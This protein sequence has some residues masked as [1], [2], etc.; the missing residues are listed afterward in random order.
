MSIFS[1]PVADALIH[2]IISSAHLWG[3]YSCLNFTVLRDV[4]QPCPRAHSECLRSQAHVSAQ[5]KLPR[6]GKPFLWGKGDRG[7]QVEGS[8]ED[9][10]RERR[11]RSRTAEGLLFPWSRLARKS[12]RG[13]ER[14]CLDDG[15]CSHIMYPQ[16]TCVSGQF[17][18]MLGT[19]VGS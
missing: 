6:N 9:R 14:A 13:L 16:S 4:G 19:S 12:E 18:H 17:Q 1:M 8:R 11:S 10:R 2:Q 7:R 5:L 3:R 15:G